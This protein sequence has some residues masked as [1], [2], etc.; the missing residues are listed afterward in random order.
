MSFIGHRSKRFLTIHGCT[1][2]QA[3]D[4]SSLIVHYLHRYFSFL[5][6]LQIVLSQIVVVIPKLRLRSQTIGI[7]SHFNIQS[8]HGSFICIMCGSP[9]GYHTP[10][11]SPFTFQNVI[12]Q[13]FMVSS[14][15]SAYFIVCSHDAPYTTT[16]YGGFK[17]RKINFIQSTITNLYIDVPAPKLLII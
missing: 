11:E 12:I 6:H 8:V 2:N 15:H 3:Q 4:T 17:C 14:M 10:V 13:E 9:V 7:R 16:L 1:E 5:N